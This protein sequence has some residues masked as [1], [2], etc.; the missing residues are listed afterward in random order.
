MSNKNKNNKG[1]SAVVEAGS[2]K[3][4]LAKVMVSELNVE[5]AIAAIS[6]TFAMVEF[7]RLCAMEEDRTAMKA[8]AQQIVSDFHRTRRLVIADYEQVIATRTRILSLRNERITESYEA[9][10]KSDAYLNVRALYLDLK[11]DPEVLKDQLLAHLTKQADENIY[12]DEFVAAEKY[13]EDMKSSYREAR[14]V[15]EDFIPVAAQHIIDE[16]AILS[17]DID[18]TREMI[19]AAVEGKP[20]QAWA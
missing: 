12:H 16:S 7:D 10:L 14:L 17:A 1:G 13:L 2:M 4:Q 3:E 8:R 18:E 6:P 19:R 20:E 11:K 9:G 5:A 15:A